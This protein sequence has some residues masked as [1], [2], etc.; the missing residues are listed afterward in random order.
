MSELTECHG[1]SSNAM[2][3]GLLLLENSMLSYID[4]TPGLQ[5]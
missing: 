1:P 5:G 2:R 4:I 3:P